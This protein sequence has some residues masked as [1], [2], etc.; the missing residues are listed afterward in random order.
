MTKFFERNST[1]LTI[2]EFYDNYKLKKYNFDAP[3]QRK[4]DVW[5]D[6]K[7]SFLIDSILKNYPMPAIFMRPIIDA[8][9]KT[10]YDIVDGKQRLQAIISFIE[11]GT[12]LTSY[13]AEDSFVGEE[14]RDAAEKI[15]GKTFSEIK[16]ED[17]TDYVKQFWT[18]TLQIEYLYDDNADLI[19]SV[20][21]RLNRNGEPLNP[22]EL[23]KARYSNAPIMFF[24]QKLTENDFW[25]D[26]LARLKIERMED[27]E[28][29]SELLFLILD[30]RVLDSSPETLDLKYEQYKNSDEAL[31]QA[32]RKFEDIIDFIKQ[33]SV[34]Y[35]K[36]KRL[37]WTTHLYTLFSVAWYC[38]EHSVS[39]EQISG[40]INEFYSNYFS[41]RVSYEGFLKEYKEASSSRTRSAV[42]R[43]HRMEAILKY[44]NVL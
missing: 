7:R 12:F 27:E 33:L 35:D 14:N 6:D 20:F 4:S 25:N 30:N 1:K 8:D 10:Q 21:D 18:Y 37:F 22:Q 26:K 42:Q 15:A 38:V 2:S 34:D 5:S 28:F 19:S 13:F 16:T 29:V 3:Y 17:S 40:A 43:N 11:G 41:K 36:H 31:E 9:G 23:R 32:K 24:V 39:A 44:C